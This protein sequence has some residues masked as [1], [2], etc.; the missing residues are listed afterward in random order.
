MAKRL[1]I[2]IVRRLDTST[3]L[4]ISTSVSRKNISEEKIN[5]LLC[6]MDSLT[7]TGDFFALSKEA[8]FWT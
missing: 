1:S 2:T 5:E 7:T 4:R 6:I 8:R 3:T